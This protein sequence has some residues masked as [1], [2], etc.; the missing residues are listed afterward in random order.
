MS[1]S[2]P[3]G[4]NHSCK[5]GGTAHID[6]LALGNGCD[7]KFEESHHILLQELCV[8]GLCL[9]TTRV[10]DTLECEHELLELLERERH[11]LTFRS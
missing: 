6:L 8:D 3:K 7:V 1:P 5:D 4:W 11:F 9:T 2:T 10:I